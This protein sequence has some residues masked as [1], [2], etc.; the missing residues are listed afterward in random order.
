MKC[1]A[2]YCS[3]VVVAVVV[4]V[5]VVDVDVV[6]LF[7]VAVDVITIVVVIVVVTVVDVVRFEMWKGFRAAKTC[8]VLCLISP[9]DVSVLSALARPRHDPPK[10]QNIGKT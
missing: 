9:D 7:V 3:G 5:V 6:V 2:V 10:P 8:N 4:A 1:S